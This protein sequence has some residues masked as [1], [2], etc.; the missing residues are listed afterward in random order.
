MPNMITIAK[1][2][3]IN[4]QVGHIKGAEPHATILLWRSLNNI[5][6]SWRFLSCGSRSGIMLVMVRAVRMVMKV[7]HSNYAPHPKEFPYA[8]PPFATR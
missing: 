5:L 3:R 8:L 7:E 4:L 1:P 6:D 2:T